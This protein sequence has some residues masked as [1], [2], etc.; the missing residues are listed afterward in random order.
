MG[1]GVLVTHEAVGVVPR[2]PSLD[3]QKLLQVLEEV[4]LL[5]VR[6][7]IV[8]NVL[9]VSL[10]VLDYVLLLAQL[11]IEEFRIRLELICETLLRLVQE[12]GFVC[13][14]LQE[15]IVNL[16]L[17]V[18]VVILSLIVTIIIKHLLHIII[19]LALLLVQIHHNIVILL[20]LLSMNGLDLL[21][22][23]SELPQLLNLRSQM[24]LDIFQLLFNLS[25]G[26]GNLLQSLVLL[27]I[28]NFFLV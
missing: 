28:K 20:F 7:S 3:L 8:L 12:F 1:V 6:F 22:L 11:G 19:H 10:Q 16:G 15:C 4:H 5:C 9:L 26:F 24:R 13:D 17:N 27:V 21:A 2:G 25:H 14:S 23:L 18:V